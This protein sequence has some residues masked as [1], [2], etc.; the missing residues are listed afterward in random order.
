MDAMGYNT[1]D[2]SISISAASAKIGGE[3][4]GPAPGLY[5][6]LGCG[7]LA[8]SMADILEYVIN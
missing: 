7:G 1:P 6:G 3:N 4:G 5:P 8:D 2:T